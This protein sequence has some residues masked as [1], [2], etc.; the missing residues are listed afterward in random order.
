M[1][2][3]EVG[4]PAAAAEARAAID[5][6]RIAPVAVGQSSRRDEARLV[7]SASGGGKVGGQGVREEG[8]ALEE[9]ARLLGVGREPE[10]FFRRVDDHGCPRIDALHEVAELNAVEQREADIGDEQIG[11]R[12]L[13]QPAR[14]I[15]CRTGR[16]VP[17]RV[18]GNDDELSCKALVGLDDED[19]W[20]HE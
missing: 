5:H 2:H 8:L 15:E 13:Q 14:D 18:S 1:E 9:S 10:V 11:V 3:L 4:G 19:D 16:R 6:Q 17:A 7:A 20:R 12:L